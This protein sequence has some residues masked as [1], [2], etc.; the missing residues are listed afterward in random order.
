M[1]RRAQRRKG[2]A[3]MA[4]RHEAGG[5]V[6]W[7]FRMVAVLVFVAILA[8]FGLHAWLRSYLHSDEFRVFMGGEVGAVMDADARFELFEWQGMHV[9]TAEFLAEGSGMIR[10]MTANDVQGNVGLAAVR[11]GVW[12]IEDLRVRRLGVVVDLGDEQDQEASGEG[13]QAPG[14]S[15]G[16]S[17]FLRSLLPERIEFMSLNIANLD[18][19]LHSAEADL[20]ATDVAMEMERGTTAGTYDVVLT[21]GGIDAPWFGSP[22]ALQRA[23]GKYNKGHLYLN[24]SRSELYERGILTLKGEVD[25]GR[26]AFF[27]TLADVRAEEIVAED[28]RKR[29]TGDLNT[30][31]KVKSKLDGI[32][33]Q[34][35]LELN[36]GIL[37]A[38]PILD[39]IAAYA[40]TQRFRRL[41]LS[42]ARLNYFKEGDR[43]DLTDIVIACEGL[44]RVVGEL[45]VLDGRLDGELRVGI[46]P[47]TLAHIPGAETKVFLRGEKGLLWAPLRIT[48]T[49]DNP[50]EDLS[51]RIVAAAGGRM[52]ELVPETGK[53]ALKFAHGTVTEL[54]AKAIEA[55]EYIVDEGLDTVREGADIIRE[56]VGGVLDLLPGSSKDDE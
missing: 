24:E 35:E 43:L 28:W 13:S 20:K 23:K 25:S 8:G 52:F 37:T 5:V 22:L 51:N 55:G 42:E 34:G 29:I 14:A 17:S 44:V 38:L 36:K 18:L 39:R 48:G 27:G 16:Q 7:L 1:L 15:D 56:G 49:I 12:E 31:F 30:R 4:Q 26:F 2:K 46:T 11:R 47:G 33:T 40:D 32:T 10:R 45:S 3:I 41:N 21:G 9:R 50:K 53:K 54:P 6:K 19:L